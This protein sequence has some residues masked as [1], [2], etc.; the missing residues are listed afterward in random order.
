MCFFFKCFPDELCFL[1]DASSPERT[2]GFLLRSRCRRELEYSSLEHRAWERDTTPDRER[3]RGGG[4]KRERKRQKGRR[5]KLYN[6]K[7]QRTLSKHF[8]FLHY[9]YTSAAA[10]TAAG[11]SGCAGKQRTV[12]ACLNVIFK[13]STGYTESWDI[14][15][16]P[17]ACGAER[18]IA[19]QY[20]AASLFPKDDTKVGNYLELCRFGVL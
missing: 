16:R 3:G 13:F 18:Y 10:A 5:R 11:I 20:G 6:I 1:T 7:R 12:S 19:S 8:V 9:S 4:G 17:A 15:R 14:N 2:P